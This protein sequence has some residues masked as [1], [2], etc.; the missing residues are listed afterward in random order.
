MRERTS[1]PGGVS[2]EP[3]GGRG[4]LLDFWFRPRR[5]ES[6][7]LYERLGARFLKRYVPTGGDLVMRWARRRRPAFRLLRGT[8]SESLH[9]FERWTRIAEAFHLVGFVAFAALAT[10]RFVTGSL[11]ILGLCAGLSLDLALGLWPVVLQRYNRLRL[12]RA[13]RAADQAAPV[14]PCQGA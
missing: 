4:R 1:H 13:M 12:Y 10:W 11:G 2:A 5:F 3:G 6:L 9:R 14:W 8:R 7:R